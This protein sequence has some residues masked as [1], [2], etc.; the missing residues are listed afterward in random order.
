MGGFRVLHITEIRT[1]VGKTGTLILRKSI[2]NRPFDEIEISRAKFALPTAGC[3]LFERTY[4]S[5]PP[6]V[7]AKHRTSRAFIIRPPQ[8]TV[9][10]FVFAAVINLYVFYFFFCSRRTEFRVIST[11]ANNPSLVRLLTRVVTDGQRV[12]PSSYGFS[13][14]NNSRGACVCLFR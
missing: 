14:S 2:V 5:T 1:L 8:V 7:L 12:F 6:T 13:V 9:V 4:P 10:S 11:S 3:D